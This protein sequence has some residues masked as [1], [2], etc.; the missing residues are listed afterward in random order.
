M[1]THVSVSCLLEQAIDALAAS[2]STFAVDPDRDFTRNRKFSL[3]NILKMLLTMED[4]C[5]QEEI[6]RFFGRTK[7]AP[8]KSA[9][10]KQ[11]QKLSEKAMPFLFRSFSSRLSAKLYN[12]KYRLFA[13]DGS[14]AE[15]FRNPNDP[16]TFFDSKAVSSTG[17]NLVYINGMYSLLDKRFIDFVIQPGRKQD[18]HSAFRYMVDSIGKTESPIIYFGDRGYSSYNNFAHV[19]ENGNYFLI[20]TSDTS[21]KS[22]IG[23][24]VDD[25]LEMDRHVDL[26]LTRSQSVKRRQHPEFSDRYRYIAGITPFEYIDDDH[27]EYSMSVRIVR[28]PLSDGSFENIVTNL[29]DLEFDFEDFIHLYHMRWGH[30][31]AY[32]EIKHVLCL[33]AFHSKKYEYIIQEIWARAILYNFS[34]AIIKDVTV[35][36]KNTINVY[37]VNYS[38]AFKTCREYMRK[39]RT[40][41]DMIDVG[42]LIARFVEPVRPGRSFARKKKVKHPF[43]FW[44]R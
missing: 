38:L 7:E 35:D 39:H 5:I 2:P 1:N 9:F 18:E 22:F 20:R 16:D 41:K 40:E 17:F 24:P 19:I 6:F 12:G 25:L 43:S 10:F 14:T 23:H 34:T 3:R 32:R 28:F 37:Q 36:K 44:Y 21:L 26:I 30:E 33:T 27:P 11:R 42:G 8:S 31:T 13:C 29:P 15:I 4:D